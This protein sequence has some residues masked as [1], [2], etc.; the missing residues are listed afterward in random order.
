MLLI[1]TL[2]DTFQLVDTFLGTI[3][4]CLRLHFTFDVVAVVAA[5]TDDDVDVDILRFRTYKTVPHRVTFAMSI[6]V[7]ISISINDDVHCF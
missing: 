3:L 1:G 7:S 2:L 5:A 6:T 4:I